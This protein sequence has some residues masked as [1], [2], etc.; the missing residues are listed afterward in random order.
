MSARVKFPPLRSHTSA[1]AAVWMTSLADMMTLLLCLFVFM[2]SFADLNAPK[3]DEFSGRMKDAFGA[4]AG[5]VGGS[6]SVIDDLTF[7]PSPS[8]EWVLAE[9]RT[10]SSQSYDMARREL[11]R[12]RT[13]LAAELRSG[14]VELFLIGGRI[15]VRFD[16]D[17]SAPLAARLLSAQRV[18][19]VL[20]KL[21]AVD[22]AL[23]IPVTIAGA[24]PAMLALAES[25]AAP[26]DDPL[27]AGVLHR[28]N[29]SIALLEKAFANEL[30]EGLIQLHPGA[31]SLVVR[32]GEGGAFATGDATLTPLALAVIAK[33]GDLART[34]SARIVIGGHTDDQPINT[35]RF[36]D[37]WDLSAARAI[38]VVRELV[39]HRGVDPARVEAQG[40][41]DTRPVAPNDS[42]ANRTL[43]RRIEIELRWP[44]V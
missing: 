17:D 2:F 30:T 24:T 36:R 12:L 25:T 4:P 7:A 16:V 23:A 15:R 33:L 9:G 38:S 35:P 44:G 20:R 13:A 18:A 42:P 8:T 29:A 27:D 37:N 3:F 40:F 28:R 41:A 5:A 34:Q 1:T 39:S 21:S 31:D 10:A 22:P 43:N 32:V 11:A 19:R 14:G 6:P 26:N